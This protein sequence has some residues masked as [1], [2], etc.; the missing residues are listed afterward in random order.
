MQR[1]KAA[2]IDPFSCEGQSPTGCQTSPSMPWNEFRIKIPNSVICLFVLFWADDQL[3]FGLKMFCRHH[4]W[5]P[6][7]VSGFKSVSTLL[8]WNMLCSVSV[9]FLSLQCSLCQLWLESLWDVSVSLI[10]EKH[11][12]SRI[13]ISIHQTVTMI[14]SHSCKVISNTWSGRYFTFGTCR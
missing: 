10:L 14:L 2:G 3:T 7:T 1:V 5:A 6:C 13:G 11:F 4:L 8:K 12:D 9:S